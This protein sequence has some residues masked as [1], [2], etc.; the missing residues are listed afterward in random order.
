MDPQLKSPPT[1][2]GIHV[3]PLVDLVIFVIVLL[4][5]HLPSLS[6]LVLQVF[7]NKVINVR[8]FSLLI[9]PVIP[10]VPSVH[11]L[12]CSH[13]GTIVL[14]NLLIIHAIVVVVVELVDGFIVLGSVVREVLSFTFI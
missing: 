11:S 6:Q 8:A 5:V 2:F 9:P 1:F 10:V 12:I 3:P 14:V 13:P 4:E 7:F